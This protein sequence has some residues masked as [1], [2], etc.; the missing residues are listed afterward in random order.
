MSRAEK[1]R[2]EKAY[3]KRKQYIKS[4]FIPKDPD[5]ILDMIF[6]DP[7]VDEM[8]SEEFGWYNRPVIYA[9]K[10]SLVP[11]AIKIGFTF[12]Y[13]ERIEEWREKYPDLEIVGGPWDAFFLMRDTLYFF[14]D[15]PVHQNA[16]RRRRA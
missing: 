10:T 13:H 9:F 3:E 11:G 14:R 12:R 15:E 5:G 16:E 6:V 4:G 8:L 2:A 7:E 1:R